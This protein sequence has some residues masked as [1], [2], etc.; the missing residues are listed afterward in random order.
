MKRSTRSFAIGLIAAGVVL[1]GCGQDVAEGAPAEEPVTVEEVDGDDLHRIT[2]S[3]RA[4]ERL[5]IEVASV[6]EDGDA[7]LIPY[8][9]LLYDADGATWTF[10]NPEGLVFVREE[11]DVDRIE[12]E[13]VRLTA[14][15]AQGT[16]VVSVGAAELWGAETGVGGGH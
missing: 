9:A 11:V 15:P 3:E 13:F 7:L 12:N 16:N 10:T 1:G 6:V 2:L 5:G 4:A 14:G 8:S